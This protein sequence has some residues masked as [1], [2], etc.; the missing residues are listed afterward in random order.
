[1]A[2]RN[3]NTTVAVRFPIK[4]LEKRWGFQGQGPFSTVDCMNIWPTQWSTGRERGGTR[5]GLVDLDGN[6]SIATVSGI[7]QNWCEVSWQAGFVAEDP[8]TTTEEY[9]AS[10]IHRGVA[11]ASTTGT[12]ITADGHEQIDA[13]SGYSCAAYL[14]YLFI[15]DER[16]AVKI[17]DLTG[18]NPLGMANDSTLEPKWYDFEGV[19]WQS[20]VNKETDGNWLDDDGLTWPAAGDP[21]VTTGTVPENCILVQ[22][23]GDRLVFAGDQHNP[24][25]LYM[26]RVGDPQ[27]FDYAQVDAGA[28]WANS[29][30]SD[31]KIGEPI[32]SLI[33]HNRDCLIV[34]CTDSLYVI[35]GNPKL[36]G[37]K[38][39]LSQVTGPLM[40]SAWC[41]DAADSTW[42]MSRDGLEMIPSGC[43][44]PAINISREP[45]PEELTA[46]EPTSGGW[47]S[48]AYDTRWRGIHIYTSLGYYFYDIQS[49]GFWPMTF[50]VAPRLAVNYKSKSSPYRSGLILV[51]KTGGSRQFDKTQDCD[52]D[53]YLWYGPFA[54]GD[55][56][57]KGIITEIAAVLARG[58][59]ADDEAK[60]EA[61]QWAI[62]KGDSPEDAYNDPNPFVGSDWTVGTQAKGS[63]RSLQ[64]TQNPMVTG[65]ACYIKAWNG[66]KKRW[67]IEEIM[68][69]HQLAGRRTVG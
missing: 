48:I 54:L 51:T 64:Y 8:E 53:A 56:F 14:Q 32:T 30:G 67:S 35:R 24:H 38:Y 25:V 40:Q 45:L 52:T 62:Y 37:Q 26:C 68:M 55:P 41:K 15:G 63:R 66:A 44:A 2:K 49:K 23:W 34:G 65:N 50:N 28:A 9:Q 17:K 27:D 22:T 31:G 7:P 21:P 6:I 10:G 13:A 4:G 20:N 29:G 58:E 43:G 19:K 3:K 60:S 1:V 46:I 11:V 57:T 33:P 12:K 36:H 42:F 47:A 16:T 69:I 61:V 39:Q 59:S 18:G 5:P